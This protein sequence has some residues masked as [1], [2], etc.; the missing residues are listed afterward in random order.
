MC[1][2][3]KVHFLLLFYS[4]TDEVLL[5]LMS[6]ANDI[7]NYEC[8]P[9]QPVN[10]CVGDTCARP[11]NPPGVG[12]NFGNGRARP[13]WFLMGAAVGFYLVALLFGN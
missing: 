2:T 8:A 3:V 6:I 1:T 5:K 11:P 10:C 7:P 9:G 4:S 13:E 12:E